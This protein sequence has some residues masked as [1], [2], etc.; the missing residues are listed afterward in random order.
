LHR[1]LAKL[2]AQIESDR[3]YEFDADSD[4]FLFEALRSQD[5]AVEEFLAK[6]LVSVEQRRTFAKQLEELSSTRDAPRWARSARQSGR[7][8]AST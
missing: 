5:F 2:E 7:S 3:R 1:D 4:R 6:E 8:T